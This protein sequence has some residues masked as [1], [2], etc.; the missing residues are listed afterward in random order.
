MTDFSM[1]IYILILSLLIYIGMCYVVA[2]MSKEKDVG[3]W[4]LLSISILF[5]PMI[6]MIYG[7]TRKNKNEKNN[8]ANFIANDNNKLQPQDEYD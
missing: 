2:Q 3:F 4:S 6:G 1:I 5:S 7:L 8:L